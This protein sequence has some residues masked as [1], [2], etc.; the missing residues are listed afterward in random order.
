LVICFKN[1]G[2]KTTYAAPYATPKINKT[3]HVLLCR[4]KSSEENFTKYLE[5]DLTPTLES[6][7]TAPSLKKALLLI[8]Q[9]WRE[10]KTIKPPNH[11]Q[12][13]GIREAVRDQNNHL[14]WNN[15]VLGR[16]SPKWQKVQQQFYTQTNSK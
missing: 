3:S 14:G 8:L 1:E 5:E 15:F 10:G 12:I 16:W 4:N 13:F 6:N 7:M 2:G 9:K 11:P